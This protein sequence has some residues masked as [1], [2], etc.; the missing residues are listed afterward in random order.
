MNMDFVSSSSVERTLR[1]IEILLAHPDGLSAA[2]LL[3]EVGGSRSA[4][5]LLLGTLKS[6]GYAEQGQRRGLYRAGARLLA[7]RAS[8]PA[9][10]VDLNLA[11]YY[12]PYQPEPRLDLRPAQSLS[13]QELN[14]FLQGPWAARLACL[15]PDGR[16][17][18]IPVWQEWDGQ[19]F[20]VLAWQGSQWADYLLRDP[21]VSLTVDEPWPPLRRVVCRG[22]AQE[23]PLDQVELASLVQRLARR[24]LGQVPAALETQVQRAFRIQPE[25]LRGWQGL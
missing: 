13:E 3:G 8:P 24:Y 17:H 22:Q 21:S 6:L 18:V 10:P 11:Y 4:L 12:L 5:F 2:E 15:R 9:V 16:P 23:I 1:V 25:T 14:T 7:W 20:R 19:A